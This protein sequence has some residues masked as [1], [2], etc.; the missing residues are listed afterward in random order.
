MFFSYPKQVITYDRWLLAYFIAS[1]AFVLGVIVDI[2]KT[3][4]TGLKGFRLPVLCLDYLEETGE[5]V[6]HELTEDLFN[7]T[8]RGIFNTVNILYI[9][10]IIGSFLVTCCE[11][12]LHYIYIW[13]LS[14]S[15]YA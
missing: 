7:T 14:S 11:Y 13:T 1:L 5:D 3:R 15:S 4:L 9:Y 8:Y 6:I 2:E 10:L 12:L